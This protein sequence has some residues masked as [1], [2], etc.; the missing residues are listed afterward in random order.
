MPLYK[1][2]SLGADDHINAATAT[3]AA[4]DK[5]AHLQAVAMLGNYT[6]IEIWEGK[7]HVGRIERRAIN[8]G[9]LDIEERGPSGRWG[10][11]LRFFF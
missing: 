9:G 4:S 11:L 7:R 3:D 2:Y 1:L 8:S 10:K 6:T 5:D